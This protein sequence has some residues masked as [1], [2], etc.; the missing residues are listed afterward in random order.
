MFWMCLMC[1]KYPR[2]HRWPA[3]P[4][5]F[6]F[7]FPLFFFLFLFFPFF[8][9]FRGACVALD[10]VWP[11]ASALRAFRLNRHR[12]CVTMLSYRWPSTYHLRRHKHQQFNIAAIHCLNGRTSLA[13]G[14]VRIWRIWFKHMVCYM[15]VYEENGLNIYA[16]LFDDS[17]LQRQIPSSPSW[18][19]S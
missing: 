15:S 16:F 12:V 4:C 17:F 5:F 3:G 7:L 9:P 18:H 2:T 1:F 11:K 13:L 8:L 14:C 19:S 6:F 10:H